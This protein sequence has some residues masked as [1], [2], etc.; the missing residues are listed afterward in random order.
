MLRIDI[1]RQH[2]PYP[3]HLQSRDPVLFVGTADE[4]AVEAAGA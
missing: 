2:G 1:H 3:A 4:K